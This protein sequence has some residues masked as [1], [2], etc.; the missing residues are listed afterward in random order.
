MTVHLEV[1]PVADNAISIETV[2][3]VDFTMQ[4]QILMALE[5]MGSLGDKSSVRRHSSVEK[6]R[7]TNDLT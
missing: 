6:R 3:A 2:L 5:M 1:P 4:A 7:C